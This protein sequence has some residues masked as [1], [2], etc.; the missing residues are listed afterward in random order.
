MSLLNISL[1][2][3]LFISQILIEDHLYAWDCVGKNNKTM[4]KTDLNFWKLRLTF[5]N[6]KVS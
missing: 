2:I 5:F 6:L 4:R 3:S 1:F